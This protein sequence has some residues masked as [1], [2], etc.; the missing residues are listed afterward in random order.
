MF[1]PLSA[2]VRLRRSQLGLSLDALSAL[3]GVS[4]TRLVTLEKGDDNISLELLVK[5]ANAMKMTE[6]QIGG[7]HVQPA[8][9][10]LHALVAAAEAVQA[11]RRV[12]DETAAAARDLERA[13]GPVYELLA[14]VLPPPDT[15]G[16]P[17]ARL[18]LAAASR[19]FRRRRPARRPA[20]VD[21]DDGQR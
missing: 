11:A 20:R 21:V 5:V 13:A 9:P 14:P 6:L 17:S 12:I 7:L 4:R 2:L 19:I 10:E 8:A 18:N 16:V 3:S 1:E 15:R